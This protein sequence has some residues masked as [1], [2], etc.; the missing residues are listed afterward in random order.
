MIKSGL[1]P[2]DKEGSNEPVHL[3]RLNRDFAVFSIDP[4]LS[5]V[6]IVVG[7]TQITNETSQVFYA[8]S[9]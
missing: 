8:C 3:C 7:S 4:K 9:W 6:E 2:A 5:M 1:N